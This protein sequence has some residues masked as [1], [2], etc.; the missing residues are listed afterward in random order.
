MSMMYCLRLATDK[1]VSELLANPDTIEEWLFDDEV[2][3]DAELGKSWH[4][5][6]FL[7]TGSQ[8]QGDEP[9]C[10]LLAGGQSIGDIDVGYGPARALTSDQI[11]S[12]EEALMKIDDDDFRA[13]YNKEELTKNEIYPK[14]WKHGNDDDNFAFLSSNFQTLKEFLQAAAKKSY[15]A[16]VWLQ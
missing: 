4:G 13:R 7:L 15:G 11:K 2:E 12:F 3:P 14:G 1:E 8:W 9:Y 5:I 10:F 16:V 6:H